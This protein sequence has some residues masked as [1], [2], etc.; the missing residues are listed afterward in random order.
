MPCHSVGDL[1]PSLRPDSGARHA[2][3][4]NVPRAPCLA[5]TP[6]SDSYTAVGDD[7]AG[8]C[9]AFARGDYCP[10]PGHGEER[11]CLHKARA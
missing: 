1:D 11:Q 4:G 3:A 7:Y 10:R 9:I 2:H 8:A 5:D 6:P